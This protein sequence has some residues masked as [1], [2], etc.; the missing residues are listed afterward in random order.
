LVVIDALREASVLKP[1]SYTE[2]VTV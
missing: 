2:R 1:Q